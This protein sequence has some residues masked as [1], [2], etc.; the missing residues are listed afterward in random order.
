MLRSG[1]PLAARIA[2][3]YGVHL[4]DIYGPSKRADIVEARDAIAAGLYAVGW[5]QVDIG[6]FLGGRDHSSVSR[7][8]TRSRRRLEPLPPERG[9]G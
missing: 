9:E 2:L 1:D 6:E 5:S 4:H 8:L 3:V 7:M